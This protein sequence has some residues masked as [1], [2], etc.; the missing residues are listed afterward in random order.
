MFDL[1]PFYEKENKYIFITLRRLK[2]LI[3]SS[4]E[5]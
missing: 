3:V 2:I 4:Q 1:I 5:N